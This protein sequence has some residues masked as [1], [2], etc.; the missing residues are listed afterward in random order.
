MNLIVL[1]PTRGRPA[2][3]LEAFGALRATAESDHRYIAL[4]DDNDPALP[5][6]E[7]IAGLEVMV[8]PPGGYTFAINFAASRL[9]DDADIFGVLQDDV[10][11]R[12]A[13]W[14]RIVEETLGTP[15]IAYGDDKI[16]GENHPTV[17]FVSSAIARA[18]GWVALPS[19]IHQY[20]DDCWKR[21]GQELGCLRFMP[22]VVME[23]MH[24]AVDKAEWDEGY[25]RVYSDGLASHDHAAF[26]DWVR[27]YMALDVANVRAALE[28]RPAVPEAPA[29]PAQLPTGVRTFMVEA[30][31]EHEITRMSRAICH[32]DGC[33]EHHEPDEKGRPQHDPRPF[34]T[35]VDD[36]RRLDTG[37]VVA[38]DVYS[39]SSC[40]IPGAMFWHDIED[41]AAD[42][43]QSGRRSAMFRSGPQL[44]VICPNGVPWIIDSRASNCTMP[45]DLEHRCWIRHGEPPTITVDKNGLT[46]AAGAGSIM[47]HGW[48]GGFDYH[49][50]LTNGEFVP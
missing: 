40:G 41:S 27:L 16:H 31:N 9:W 35:T 45:D 24:V 50:F 37:E 39:M 3:C 7:A 47:A 23:H 43:P 32:V 49:G 14:D 36:V 26:Q 30:F 8:V 11:S 20:V 48:N 1:I 18:L 2:R 4:V 29:A 12:T 28:G 19:T 21:L 44:S 46:C 33:T 38:T 15:G 42:N 5:E 34:T 10:L 22:D 17:P 6:Y 13:G 25:R